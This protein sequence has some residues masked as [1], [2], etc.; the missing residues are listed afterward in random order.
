[1]RTGRRP[2]KT[3]NFEGLLLTNQTLREKD[4]ADR[5]FIGCALEVFKGSNERAGAS[6]QR[7]KNWLRGM[8][9]PDEGFHHSSPKVAKNGGNYL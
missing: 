8:S 9:F 5:I 4:V 6:A 3:V 2:V 1:M 7:W